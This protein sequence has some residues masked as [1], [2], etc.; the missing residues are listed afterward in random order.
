MLGTNIH[1]KTIPGPSKAVVV[2]DTRYV[3]TN[4][5]PATL[6]SLNTDFQSRMKYF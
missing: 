3:L 4:Y 6:T 5:K 1:S 2:P